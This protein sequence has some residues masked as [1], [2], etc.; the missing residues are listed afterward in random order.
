MG[1]DATLAK[2]P[3]SVMDQEATVALLGVRFFHPQVFVKIR[4]FTSDF[5]F[6]PLDTS[7]KNQNGSFCPLSCPPSHFGP[8]SFLPGN[9][10]QREG[11]E[12][13]RRSGRR[14][15]GAPAG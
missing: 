15:S 8:V 13:P 4:R 3:R 14:G 9:Q 10:R 1:A 7:G 6:V 11:V 12:V 2:T 5:R